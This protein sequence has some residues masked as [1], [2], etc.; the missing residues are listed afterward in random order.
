[1]DQCVICIENMPIIT[2]AI[3]DFVGDPETGTPTKE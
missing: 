3:S 1:M 2:E